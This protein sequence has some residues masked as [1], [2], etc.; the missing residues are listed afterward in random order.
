MR[1]RVVLV[2]SHFLEHKRVKGLL[3][4]KIVGTV[5][6]NIAVFQE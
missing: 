5:I 2:G 3:K 4:T 1:G 6:L